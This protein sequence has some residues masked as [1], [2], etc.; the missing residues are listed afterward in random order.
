MAA[1][2]RIMLRLPLNILSRDAPIE[3]STQAT[4]RQSLNTLRYSDIVV[5]PWPLMR[6]GID[7]GSQ[8]EEE[9]FIIVI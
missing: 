5:Q 4:N 2:L 7:P 8:L 3:L 6:F 9:R 1:V